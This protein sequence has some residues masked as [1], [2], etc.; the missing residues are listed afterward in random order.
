M[1]IIASL[2]LVVSSLIAIPAQA[3]LIKFDVGS[4]NGVFSGS[5][6]TGSFVLNTDEQSLSNI[7]L[8]SG[9]G[10]F[11]SSV[12]ID[13]ASGFGLQQTSFFF[14]CVAEL[15]FEIS[16]FDRFMPSLAVGQSVSVSAFV[17]QADQ[18]NASF[19]NVDPFSANSDIFQGNIMATRLNDVPTPA[20]L[21]FIAVFLAGVFFVK[22]HRGNG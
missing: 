3:D 6:L 9:A 21:S 7:S 1:K 4:L 22:R 11:M 17:S 13:N 16:G 8:M 10:A 19:Q 15:L 18:F 20:A 2:L 12:A 14:E 5:P